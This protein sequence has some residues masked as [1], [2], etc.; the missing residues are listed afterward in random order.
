[1]LN[2]CRTWIKYNIYMCNWNIWYLEEILNTREVTLH[3]R[4][5][6]EFHYAFD[7]HHW[8]C[9]NHL[10]VIFKTTYYTC[11]NFWQLWMTSWKVFMLKFLLI[12]TLQ[13]FKLVY[14]VD[15]LFRG[16]FLLGFT[17]SSHTHDNNTKIIDMDTPLF[18]LI[19]YFITW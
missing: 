11:G 13:I 14:L 12:T 6:L 18:G 10:H 7:Q 5:I 17:C 8:S 3:Q 16:I 4:T 19:T 1:M 2:L 9:L 15:S